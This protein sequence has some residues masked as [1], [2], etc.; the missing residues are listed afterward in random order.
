MLFVVAQ[1]IDCA[2]RAGFLIRQLDAVCLLRLTDG[3][4]EADWTPRLLVKHCDA[5]LIESRLEQ[6]F[7][8]V[9]QVKQDRGARPSSLNPLN[10]ATLTR[11]EKTALRFR[12][13]A[14][15]RSF[16]RSAS[17]IRHAWRTRHA[18]SAQPRLSQ[19]RMSTKSA[20]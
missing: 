12:M 16:T 18:S 7:E 6:H 11:S 3:R 14:L 19:M 8:G 4:L 13:R 2:K 15:L 17:R 1:G 10:A 5:S 20:G 9:L